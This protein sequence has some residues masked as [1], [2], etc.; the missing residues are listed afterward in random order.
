MIIEGGLIR[1]PSRVGYVENR[2]R[3]ARR[4][5]ALDQARNDGSG[6]TRAKGC[7]DRT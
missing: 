1:D 2:Y 6:R 5:G 7:T 3:T 4:V